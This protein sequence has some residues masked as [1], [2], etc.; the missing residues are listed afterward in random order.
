MS[1][2]VAMALENCTCNFYD[3]D[4]LLTSSTE[5]FAVEII[6]LFACYQA[7]AVYGAGGPQSPKGRQALD[8]L[9]RLLQVPPMA[10]KAYSP[11]WVATITR[12]AST[13]CPRNRSR[14]GTVYPSAATSIIAT[15]ENEG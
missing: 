15:S 4:P 12:L 7:F 9:K 3:V 5:R 6:R 10:R 13:W 11:Y 1:F 8:W 14:F 2:E